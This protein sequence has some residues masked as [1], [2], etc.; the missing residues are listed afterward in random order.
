MEPFA[1]ELGQALGHEIPAHRLVTLDVD[2]DDG[3]RIELILRSAYLHGLFV[4]AGD[5]GALLDGTGFVF[6][7]VTLHRLSNTLNS[8]WSQVAPWTIDQAFLDALRA[9]ADAACAVRVTDLAA[10]SESSAVHGVGMTAYLRADGGFDVEWVRLTGSGHSVDSVRVGTFA[11]ARDLLM[12][13]VDRAPTLGSL[14]WQP[15]AVDHGEGI[16]LQSR[17][18]IPL[19]RLDAVFE[20]PAGT[21]VTLW[22]IADVPLTYGTTPE[23]DYVA[24]A[25][26][27]PFQVR[28][29][30]FGDPL[31]VLGVVHEYLDGNVEKVY[32]ILDDEK[33]LL[34]EDFVTITAMVPPHREEYW[35]GSSILAF[36]RE[37]IERVAM[38]EQRPIDAQ[39]QLFIQSVNNAL[40]HSLI[41]AEL[42]V[43]EAELVT[44][45][46]P[47]ETAGVSIERLI[48]LAR[49][50]AVSLVVGGSVVLHNPSRTALEGA[51]NLP[52]TLGAESSYVQ[53]WAVTTPTT[54]LEAFTG[55]SPALSLRCEESSAVAAGERDTAC[56]AD[57]PDGFT[58][59][60]VDSDDR[61]YTYDKP[62]PLEAA[63]LFLAFTEDG[64]HL[65]ESFQWSH[66]S[67]PESEDQPRFV[68]TLP[69]G[70]FVGSEEN[71]AALRGM[72]LSDAG[73]WLGL[74]DRKIKGGYFQID[75]VG[76]GRFLVEWGHNLGEDECF[77]T[78]RESLAEAFELMELFLR[79]D[80][81]DFEAVEWTRTVE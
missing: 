43:A 55:F 67:E 41:L 11:E 61:R 38:G 35:L 78:N 18:Q 1:A 16:S 32:S 22:D 21:T 27:G 28:S 48:N 8:S 12:Q 70:S 17:V 65:K 80:R 52:L 44:M 79:D 77:Q 63:Q 29:K 15:G 39:M 58:F 47:I 2:P 60:V 20:R 24:S 3:D 45:M 31:D 59:A 26:L 75:N 36:H 81:T 6:G 23:G 10:P 56:F 51:H 19:R 76:N 42:E 73:D 64:D 33:N 4:L 34:G 68:I 57:T 50:F 14:P 7:E 37:A 13:V 62:T 25:R 9:P 66:V 53:D 40:G 72:S 69:S 49:E 54:L 71:F 5:S 74:R 30:T 46:V